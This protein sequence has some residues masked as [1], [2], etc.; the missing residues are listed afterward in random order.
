[1]SFKR[2]NVFIIIVTNRIEIE[3]N[4]DFR[5]DPAQKCQEGRSFDSGSERL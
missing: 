4:L 1:M 5:L 3:I 2:Y